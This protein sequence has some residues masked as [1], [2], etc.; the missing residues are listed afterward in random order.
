MGDVIGVAVL[1]GIGCAGILVSSLSITATLI[2]HNTDSSAFVYGAM[3]LTDKVANGIA[4]VAVQN[5][6]PCECDCED[7][8]YFFRAV[9][10]IGVGS[11]TIA[12][13][14][15]VIFHYF[16]CVR[17]QSREVSVYQSIEE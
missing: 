4:V 2:G 15:F 17:K 7:C 13:C 5:L 10:T 9:L 11:L 3:S 1:N 6:D 8:G 16:Y 14:L 12:G